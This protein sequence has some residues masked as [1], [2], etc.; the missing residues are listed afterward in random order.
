LLVGWLEFGCAVAGA[1]G[2]LIW[3]CGREWGD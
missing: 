3:D 2:L 1:A